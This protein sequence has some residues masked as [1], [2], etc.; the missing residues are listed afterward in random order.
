V[1]TKNQRFIQRHGC[2][3]RVWQHAK[4]RRAKYFGKGLFLVGGGEK[5]H[6]VYYGTDQIVCDCRNQEYARNR[7]CC[8]VQAVRNWLVAYAQMQRK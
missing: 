6:V 4:K 3:I 7:V 5:Q 8:H 1:N 2:S